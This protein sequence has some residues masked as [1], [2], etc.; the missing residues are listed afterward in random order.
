MIKINLLPVEAGKRA[1]SAGKKVVRLP[2]GGLAPWVLG[3]VLVYIAI[4]YGGYLLY[5]TKMD[6][7]AS[8]DQARALKSRKE[9][10]VKR[11]QEAFDL[12]NAHSQEIEEK[13]QVVQALTENRI[14]W[15]E[16]LNMIARARMDLA[17][18]ITKL[19]LDEKI[20]EQETPESQKRREEWRKQPKH[21]P[22]DTEPK[23]VMRPIINQWITIYA[24]AYGN[25]SAQRLQQVNA[26]QEV[27][28]Q[29]TWERKNGNTVR[30]LDGMAPEFAQLDQR[31]DM[32]AG[33]EVLRFGLVC[34]AE[35]QMGPT[36]SKGV[37]PGAPGAPAKGGR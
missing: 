27:L 3:L 19:A 34:R 4:G 10:E 26:F 15:S 11:R 13:Y 17:V 25:S 21:M 5:R 9:R 2:R 36:A 24:I 20:D 30:F 32:V 33:V 7:K 35:P 16:K 23:R 18:Y 1:G 28:R 12:A 31:V 37:V 14:F 6:S 22:G 8:V 29:L